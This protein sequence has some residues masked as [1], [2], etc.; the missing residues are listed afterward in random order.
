MKPDDDQDPDRATRRDGEDRKRCRP[1]DATGIARLV[2]DAIK[3]RQAADSLLRVA[4]RVAATGIEPMSME[5]IDA[6]IKAY[7]AERRQRPGGH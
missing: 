2:T 7:R 6:K 5:K 3:R 1:A 4:D